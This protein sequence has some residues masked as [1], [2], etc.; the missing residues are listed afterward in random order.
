MGSSDTPLGDLWQALNRFDGAVND[1]VLG[2]LADSKVGVR[3]H[4]ALHSVAA[5]VLING[6]DDHFALHLQLR[7]MHT[8]MSGLHCNHKRRSV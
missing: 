7:T 2:Q 6:L 1:H 3:V 5:V 8:D 4:L